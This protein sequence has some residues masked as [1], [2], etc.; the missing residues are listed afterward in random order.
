[1][2][3]SDY[4]RNE[5]QSTKWGRMRIN[6]DLVAQVIKAKESRDF[7]EPNEKPKI[8]IQSTVK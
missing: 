6:Y 4:L 8:K 7:F 3:F 2:I 5:M 1:M